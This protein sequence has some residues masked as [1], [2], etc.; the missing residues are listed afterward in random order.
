MT[1]Y[2]CGYQPGDNV[3]VDHNGWTVSGS[4]TKL[5][6]FNI[7]VD[8]NGYRKAVEPAQITAEAL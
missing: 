2:G 8:M 1:T 6:P 5:S 4:I 7:Y 3:T